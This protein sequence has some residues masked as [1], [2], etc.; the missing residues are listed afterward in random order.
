VR[1]DAALLFDH[2]LGMALGK[3]LAEVRR[4]PNLEWIQWAAF[5]RYRSEL[6]EAAFKKNQRTPAG[7]RGR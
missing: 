6:E 3:S 7:R 2:T 5:L 4:M 1:G